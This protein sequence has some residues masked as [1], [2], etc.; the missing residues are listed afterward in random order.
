[1]SIPLAVLMVLPETWD[2]ARDVNLQDRSAAVAEGYA[3]RWCCV[4]GIWF[5]YLFLCGSRGPRGVA[6]KGWGQPG[7]RRG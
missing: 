7:Q 6:R 1:M 4:V 3:S 2:V 5:E